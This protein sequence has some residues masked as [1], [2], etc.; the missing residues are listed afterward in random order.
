M[1]TKLSLC[2]AITLLLMC[3]TFPTKAQVLTIENGIALSRL[4]SNSSELDMS[5][6]WITPYQLSVGLDYLDHGWFALSSHIGYL[7]KGGKAALQYTPYSYIPLKKETNFTQKLDYFTFNTT[8]RV[9]G[10]WIERCTFYAGVGPRLDVFLSQTVRTN[11][12]NVEYPDIPSYQEDTH[13]MFSK[14]D[15]IAF[16]LTCEVGI[17]YTV[18]RYRIGI[19]AAWLPNFTKT[20]PQGINATWLPKASNGTYKNYDLYD[21]TFTLGLVLGYVL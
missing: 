17:D 18:D 14:P 7:R 20:I 2:A 11:T 16:G 12:I 19:H 1:K 9:Q 3:T 6:Q 8:F 15:N 13:K 4:Y 10:H 21:N 5:E